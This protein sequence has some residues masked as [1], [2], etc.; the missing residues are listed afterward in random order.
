MGSHQLLCLL[1]QAVELLDPV[2]QYRL[3]GPAVAL[4]SRGVGQLLTL[5]RVTN[6]IAHH[7]PT[8]RH[9]LCHGGLIVSSQ[10]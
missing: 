7:T 4:V 5:L 8:Y 6:S 10:L 9:V 1:G 3:V 2:H